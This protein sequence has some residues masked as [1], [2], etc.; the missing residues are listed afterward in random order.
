MQTYLRQW[1]SSAVW[2]GKDGELA[3]LRER[4]AAIQTHQDA[5]INVRT[6]AKPKKNGRTVRGNVSPSLLD[7]LQ[8]A[9]AEHRFEE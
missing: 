9:T 7:A 4:V 5:A 3:A 6:Q 2:R 8:I 1:V